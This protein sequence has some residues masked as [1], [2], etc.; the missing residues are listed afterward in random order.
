MTATPSAVCAFAL[1]TSALLFAAPAT[2]DPTDDAFIG[3]LTKN[4]ITVSDRDSATSMAQAV[5]D[6][7]D[8]H[9]KPSLM[10]MKLMKQSGLSLKQSSYFVGVAISAYCPE[11][12]GHTDTSAA[13]LNPGPPLM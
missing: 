2:A 12:L 1:C 7:F 5:C 8:H 13:W 9:Q 10:A 3:A 6:G 4:G 11:Y